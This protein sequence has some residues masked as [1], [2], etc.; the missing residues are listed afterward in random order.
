MVSPSTEKELEELGIASSQIQLVYNGA[1]G[2]PP[3]VTLP[4]KKSDYFLWLS[5]LHRYKGIYT[6]LEAFRIFSKKYPDVKLRIA[7]GGP[8]LKKM[9]KIIERYGLT[10]K[11]ILEG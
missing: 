11:V 4:L 3:N 8:L 7:G 10:G 6:A 2:L 1:D 9:P 5:R